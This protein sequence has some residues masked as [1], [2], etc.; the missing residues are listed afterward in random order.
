[1]KIYYKR[2]FSLIIAVMMIISCT[3]VTSA[4]EADNS[5]VVKEYVS[6]DIY[7]ENGDIVPLSSFH[8]IYATPASTTLGSITIP[9]VTLG[10]NMDLV[11]RVN[12]N[13]R[14]K[15]SIYQWVF[16]TDGSI[17]YEL[18]RGYYCAST[19]GAE[20]I[21]SL[22]NGYSGGLYRIIISRDGT[23]SYWFNLG[24]VY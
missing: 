15:V 12:S 23:G 7:P 5:N 18:V 16:H 9:E 19:G 22:G 21:Y 13:V 6:Q 4:A 1:M 14:L 2:I 20:K 3:V 10:G 11:I 17:T 8:S 24:T